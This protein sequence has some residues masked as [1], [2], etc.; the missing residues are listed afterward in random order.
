MT[1]HTA[2][3]FFQNL[4]FELTTKLSVVGGCRSMVDRRGQKC[5]CEGEFVGFLKI[6]LKFLFG[7]RNLPA[8]RSSRPRSGADVR[9]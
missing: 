9:N 3:K 7:V 1:P 8:L 5:S 2:R 6:Y 4:K